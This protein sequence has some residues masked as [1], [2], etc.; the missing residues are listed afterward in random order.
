M[1]ESRQSLEE[2]TQG[3]GGGGGNTSAV[4][5]CNSSERASMRSTAVLPK[6]RPRGIDQTGHSL[7]QR[8]QP[9]AS[10]SR[11]QRARHG[12]G[13]GATEHDA[14]KKVTCQ[15]GGTHFIW[16]MRNKPKSRAVLRR[17]RAN[18]MH[19]RNLACFDVPLT[20]S[21]CCATPTASSRT[22]TGAK[23]IPIQAH[24]NQLVSIDTAQTRKT[25]PNRVT[26]A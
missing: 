2:C 3:K 20:A 17:G 15:T 10:R 6:R 24:V 13:V 23:P 16:T 18:T 11:T 19:E 12:G 21:W 7:L 9:V 22:Y 5:T 14:H 25:R 8:P 4:R 1:A 26:K